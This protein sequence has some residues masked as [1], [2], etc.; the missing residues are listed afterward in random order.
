MELPLS[1]KALS[2][3]LISTVPAAASV[4]LVA[5]PGTT[6]YVDE[7]V[8]CPPIAYTCWNETGLPAS[9]VLSSSASRCNRVLFR[10][11]KVCR[12]RAGL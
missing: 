5:R 10:P 8:V 3:L 4:R 2:V 12:R 11:A 1:L 7:L 9:R 6:L